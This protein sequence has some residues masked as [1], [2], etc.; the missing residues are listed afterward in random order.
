M[1]IAYEDY[2]SIFEEPLSKDGS[3]T[4]HQRNLREVPVEM[5]KI[6]YELSQDFMSDMVE[7]MNT[8]HHTI[9]SCTII[10]Y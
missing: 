3:A 10:H 8:K 2:D 7:E 9:S 5:C 4:I 6:T 1:R